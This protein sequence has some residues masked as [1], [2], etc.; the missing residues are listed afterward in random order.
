[1]STVELAGPSLLE[2]PGRAAR[3]VYLTPDETGGNL[4]GVC[5]RD[6]RVLRQLARRTPIRWA[7]LLCGAIDQRWAIRMIPRGT[8]RKHRPDESSR[9][10]LAV[11]ESAERYE[12]IP[13]AEVDRERLLALFPELTPGDELP[14]PWVLFRR[15]AFEGMEVTV[16]CDVRVIR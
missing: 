5:A 14:P 2:A 3:I 11:A 1:M 6:D 4:R 8:R 16:R 9:L 7:D 15:A 10:T 13:F 12:V